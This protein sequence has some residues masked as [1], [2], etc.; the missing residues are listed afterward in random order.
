M[1]LADPADWIANGATDDG[2]HAYRSS[3]L[4]SSV[5]LIVRTAPQRRQEQVVIDDAWLRTSFS[6]DQRQDHVV[7]RLQQLG[8][9][10]QFR[11]PEFV[12][13][14]VPPVVRLDRREV[15]PERRYADSPVWSIPVPRLP[16]D[17]QMSVRGDA[18][19]DLFG[20]GR[21]LE[22][23]YPSPRHNRGWLSRGD[24]PLALPEIEGATFPPGNVLGASPSPTRTLVEHP[25]T[26]GFG[27]TAGRDGASIGVVRRR[28]GEKSSPD[29]GRRFPDGNP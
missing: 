2:H 21:T 3:S 18:G 1:A 12:G 9:R 24:V 17:G 16:R 5:P 19:D 27:K 11:L 26:V 15:I 29:D 6:E 14:D 22:I 4:P 20:R 28:R 25:V 7:M 8:D 13:S 23:Q 10:L